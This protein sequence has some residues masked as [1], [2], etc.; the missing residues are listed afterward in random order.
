VVRKYVKFLE[1][2]YW[3]DQEDETIDNQ[4]IL[5]QIDE[6]AEVLVQQVSPPRLQKLQVQRQE[7]HTKNSSSSSS[8]SVGSMRKKKDPEEINEHLGDMDQQGHSH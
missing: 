1:E 5:L 4:N 8:D 6:Q 2:K 7:E 3:S